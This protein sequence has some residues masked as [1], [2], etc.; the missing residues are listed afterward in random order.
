MIEASEIPDQKREV[1]LSMLL[2]KEG[3]EQGKTLGRMI[4]PSRDPA[5]PEA[6]NYKEKVAEI[7]R[8]RLILYRKVVE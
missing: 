3:K 7:R 4:E 1:G 5:P 8:K 2:K 6:C